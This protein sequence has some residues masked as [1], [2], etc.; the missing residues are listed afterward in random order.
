MT[1]FGKS[2]I[3]FI[4]LTPRYL[5]AVSIF[6]GLLLFLPAET[7]NQ[8]GADEFADKHRFWLGALF[9]ASLTLWVVA[10]V[11]FGW[12]AISDNVRHW[13]LKQSVRKRLEELTEEEKEVL[14]YYIQNQTRTNVLRID[15]GIIRGLVS[16]HV[17]YQAANLGRLS[18]GF[19][20]NISDVAWKHLNKNPHLLS[21]KSKKARTDKGRW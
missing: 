15:D 18:S 1:D 21:G 13:L 16:S 2:F 14:R 8:I 3:E 7:L 6:C 12:V 4:K 11:K 20:H 10:M 17:I 9:L 5:V 19:S